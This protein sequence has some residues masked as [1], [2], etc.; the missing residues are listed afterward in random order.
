VAFWWLGQLGYAL[1]FGETVVYIDAYLAAEAARLVPPLLAAGEVVNADLVFGTHDHGDHIDRHAWPVI[2]TS[3]PRARFVAPGLL[4]DRLSRELRMPRSRFLE[5]D[6]GRAIE[7]DGLKITGIAAA[8]EFLDRDGVTGRYPCL[9][10]VIE[11]N[12]VT[13]YHAGDS[14]IYDGLLGKLSAFGGIDVAFLPIN[15]RDGRRY[16]AGCIGNMTFQEAVDLAGGLAVGVAVP[17]HYDMFS[18]NGEDPA[19]FVD[20]L[21]AKYPSVRWWTGEHGVAVLAPE[22][23]AARDGRDPIGTR[24]DPR[25]PELQIE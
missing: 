16:R 8:H 18:D 22:G 4:V 21:S 17:A 19:R 25:G 6:D 15:G 20:Y 1:K 11:A 2:A 14:C 23:P 24:D 3:S 10:Y 13:V 9:G 5:A 7:G 12:G